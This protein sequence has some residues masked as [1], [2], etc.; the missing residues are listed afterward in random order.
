MKFSTT[1]KANGLAFVEAQLYTKDGKP[2]GKPMVFKVNVTS[3][4]STVLL[5][6][7]GGVL[8]VVLAGVRMYTTRKRN[9]GP[10]SDEDGA[11]AVVAPD[12][13]APDSSDE[14]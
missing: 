3:I 7:A 9:G 14:R 1:A 10:S 4:T 11:E 8:L 12:G 5:V 2:Y 13:D 6:I